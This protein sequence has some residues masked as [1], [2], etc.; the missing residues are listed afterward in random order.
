MKRFDQTYRESRS[1]LVPDLE[2]IR[3]S[4]QPYLLY[5]TAK[6]G[7]LLPPVTFPSV[8]MGK[9]RLS[10]PE[11]NSRIRQDGQSAE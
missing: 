7:L 9:K 2:G 4:P 10:E 11:N 1:N 5:F 8:E 3:R 6:E